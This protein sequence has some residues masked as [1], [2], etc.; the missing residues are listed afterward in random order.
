MKGLRGIGAGSIS[1]TGDGAASA[2]SVGCVPVVVSG[3][4]V[5]SPIRCGSVPKGRGMLPAAERVVGAGLELNSVVARASE[6]VQVG[7]A[8]VEI[9][10]D[11][12]HHV[13]QRR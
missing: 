12:I 3:P 4:A 13:G 5:P 8:S 7:V 9:A 6:L 1:E 11:T 10:R 2:R